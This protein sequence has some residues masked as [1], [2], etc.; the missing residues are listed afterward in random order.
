V[1]QAIAR[2]LAQAGDAGRFDVVAQLAR[3]LEARRL[4]RAGNVVRLQDER[5]KRGS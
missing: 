1:E 3:E 5:E 2:A 4:A